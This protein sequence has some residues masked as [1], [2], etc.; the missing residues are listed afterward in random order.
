MS[1]PVYR[2]LEIRWIDLEPTRGSETQK[3]RPCVI[4]QADIIN[5]DSK[6]IIIAPLLPG[7]K[8]WPFAVNVQPSKNNGLDKERHINLKQIRV[9]DVSRILNRQG[10]LEQHYLTVIQEA[11]KIVFAL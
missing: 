8:N 11:I 1:S 4:I 7:H 2:Q 5:R 3:K 6:T 9:V 10:I